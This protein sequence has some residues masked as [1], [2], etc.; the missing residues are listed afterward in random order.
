MSLAHI[1]VLDHIVVTVRDLAAAAAQWKRLG[2]T[3]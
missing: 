3:V 1:Q 2:F